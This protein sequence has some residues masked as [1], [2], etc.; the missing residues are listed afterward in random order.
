MRWPKRARCSRTR[1][2]L[3]DRRAVIGRADSI[4]TSLR[5]SVVG[6]VDLVGNKEGLPR[7]CGRANG[8]TTVGVR[9]R[10][11]SVGR[12]LGR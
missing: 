7:A 8:L 12:R 5:V 9:R 1:T 11:Q 2:D 6:V 3:Q 10:G 4:E